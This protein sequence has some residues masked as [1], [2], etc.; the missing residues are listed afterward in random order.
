MACGGSGGLLDSN[1]SCSICGSSAESTKRMVAL[2]STMNL[3]GAVTVSGNMTCTLVLLEK[4]TIKTQYIDAQWFGRDELRL[5][6]IRKLSDTFTCT[7]NHTSGAAQ[8]IPAVGKTA[9]SSDHN[10]FNTHPRSLYEIPCR[11]R[12]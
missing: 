12:L 3:S 8:P 1:M 4:S 10:T 7:D 2:P 9:K 11:R 6:P 5:T